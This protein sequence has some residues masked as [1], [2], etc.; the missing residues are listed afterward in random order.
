MV[1]PP[2]GFRINRALPLGRHPITEAFPGIE[3]T[4]TAIR[5]TPD[6]A[7]RRRLFQETLVEIV[8]QDMW[9]YVA[10]WSL[11]K[12]LRRRWKP[13]VA[14]GA[15]CIVIGESHLRESP[16]LIVFLDIFHELCHVRQ[17]R[18]G[19]ELF[20]RKESYVRRPTEIEAYQFAVAEARLL[21]VTNE[22]LREYLKVEWVTEP[23]IEELYRT[24]GVDGPD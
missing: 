11:P 5:H 22:V 9:M 7:E 13:V 21:G 17:R 4:E 18:A 19:R 24:L 3:L 8:D 23:E 10:P 14:P 1:E 20:D 12:G 16:A 15:D 2:A 6:P